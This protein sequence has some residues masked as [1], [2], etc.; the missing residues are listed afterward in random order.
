MNELVPV[1]ENRAPALIAADGE[2]ASYPLLRILHGADQEP[3][4][5]P[6]LCTSGDGILRLG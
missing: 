6:R 5:P 2:R 3:A 1:T 4:H